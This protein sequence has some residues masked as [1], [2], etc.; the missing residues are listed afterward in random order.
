[1]QLSPTQ[2]LSIILLLEVLKFSAR[3]R[4]AAG[5]VIKNENKR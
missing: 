3:R 2:L 5:N 1:M 4:K